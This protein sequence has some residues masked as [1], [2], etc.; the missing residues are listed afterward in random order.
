MIVP[1]CLILLS[2][3]LIYP[4]AVQQACQFM[5]NP[6]SNHLQAA[7]QIL[8]YLQGIVHQGLA[9]TPGSLV[10][11]A[12]SDADWAGDPLDRKSISG[13][14]VFLGNSPI[15]WSAKKQPTVSRSSIEAE[16]RALAFASTELC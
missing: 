4:F 14:L 13:I 2:V 10:L 5:A 8:R 6:T 12:Y 7:K 3:G 1:Y 9:F 16:Y 11:S 15:T